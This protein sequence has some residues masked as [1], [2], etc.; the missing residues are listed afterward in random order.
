LIFLRIGVVLEVQGLYR[1][2]VVGREI[3]SWLCFSML[4]EKETQ[5]FL[6]SMMAWALTLAKTLAREVNLAELRF[7]DSG[8]YF[9]G[10][11]GGAA[12]ESL[13]SGRL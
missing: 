11:G 4:S 8:I 7:G 9:F 1:E 5:V 6:K 13:L 12:R 10:V 2:L 3:W